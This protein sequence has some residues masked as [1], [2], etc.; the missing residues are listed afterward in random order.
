MR[1]L[2]IGALAF[3][4]VGCT[5]LPN[6]D[7]RA[8]STNSKP[9][10]SKVVAQNVTKSTNPQA[11][12]SAQFGKKT[13]VAA[14]AKSTVAGKKAP[15]L[16]AQLNGTVGTAEPAIE[17]AK[18]SIAGMMANPASAE[19][20]KLKRAVKKLPDESVDTICGYVKGKN[21]SGG[22]TGEMAFLYIIRNNREGEAYLVDGKS[23][24]AQTVHGVLCD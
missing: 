15:L 6:L 14:R 9:R 8:A 1:T 3:N 7:P 4:L 13:K 16:P 11:R 21:A 2:F 17:K 10:V 24:T 22:D 18:A 20:Y 5:F 12:S 23:Y 19:F